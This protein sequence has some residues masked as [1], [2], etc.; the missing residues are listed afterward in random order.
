MTTYAG[1]RRTTGRDDPSERLWVYGRARLPCRRCGT[2]IEVRKHGNGCE[3]DLLVS[4]VSDVVIWLA[5]AGG[6]AAAAAAL[7]GHYYVLPGVADRT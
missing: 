5:L 1:Y 3:A 6:T 4:G 7:Y 2:A